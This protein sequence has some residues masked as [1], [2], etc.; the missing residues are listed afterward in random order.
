MKVLGNTS[1]Y[2]FAGNHRRDLGYGHSRSDLSTPTWTDDNSQREFRWQL[3][4]VLCPL[5]QASRTFTV[6]KS[7]SV[8]R[9]FW[10]QRWS[11]DTSVLEFYCYCCSSSSFFLF[12][13]SPPLSLLPHTISCACS[14]KQTQIFVIF[15][16]SAINSIYFIHLSTMDT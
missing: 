3:R 11:T 7:F 5:F 6:T 2:G 13:S 16:W 9:P 12:F 8:L 4:L 1:E 14:L 10:I 15:Y